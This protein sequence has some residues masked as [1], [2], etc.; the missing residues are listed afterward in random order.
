MPLGVY[1]T[2]RTQNAPGGAVPSITV[3]SHIVGAASNRLLV[4]IVNA[5]NNGSHAVTGITR[6]AQ[7][8]T[9]HDTVAGA[10]GSEVRTEL[11]YLK[12]VNAD[13]QDVV[14]SWSPDTFGAVV[15]LNIEDADLTA[16]TFG[17]VAKVFHDSGAGITNPSVTVS[18][19]SGELIVGACVSQEDYAIT[20]GAGQTSR[21]DIVARP[22]INRNRLVVST[23]A[24]GTSVTHDYTI[25][26][27]PTRDCIIA[28]PIRPAGGGGGGGGAYHPW[29]DRRR[30]A[31]VLYTT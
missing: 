30:R 28:V 20:V 5:R 6:G 23:E 4:A 27:A 18:S 22:A 8:L 31:S 15:L 1:G 10:A 2:V 12:N 24:G 3:T 11:W 19:A 16:N 29:L 14:V 9:L 21:A 25:A 13:T 7:S 26:T 17:T